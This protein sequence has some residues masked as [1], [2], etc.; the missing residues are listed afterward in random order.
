MHQLPGA[1]ISRNRKIGRINGRSEKPSNFR[2]EQQWS[3]QVRLC[4]ISPNGA[5]GRFDATVNGE[6]L[7]VSSR[8]PFLDAARIL[9]ERGYDTNSV[10]IA[11]HAGSDINCLIAK[12]GV[13]AALTVAEG[14]RD[15]P[16]FRSWKAMPSREGS[17]PVR[18]T[19]PVHA[20]VAGAVQ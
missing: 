8:T 17:V 12:I 2:P 20:E 9:V 5:P 3:D 16:R 11:R 19:V 13:A 10:L 15:A 1:G 6:Q 7:V 4:V 14:E 18:K